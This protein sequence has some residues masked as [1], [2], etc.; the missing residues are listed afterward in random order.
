MQ[1]RYIKDGPD[2]RLKDIADF[3]QKLYRRKSDSGEESRAIT[4]IIYCRAKSNCDAVAAF[5][6]TKGI[7]AAAYH[8]GLKDDSAKK[9]QDRWMYNELLAEKGKPRIDCIG[10]LFLLCLCIS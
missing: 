4:G 10:V 6:K 1:V 8:R 7:N 5:L 3:I 2:H 9:A